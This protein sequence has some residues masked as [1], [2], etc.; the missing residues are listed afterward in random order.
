MK[1]GLVGSLL[2]GERNIRKIRLQPLCHQW[3][4][5]S[6][7]ERDKR[8]GACN[9]SQPSSVRERT[10]RHGAVTVEIV[11]AISFCVF[12]SSG[13]IFQSY[14]LQ[15]VAKRRKKNYTKVYLV[16]DNRSLCSFSS[17]HGPHTHTHHQC[18]SF[19]MPFCLFVCLFVFL[20]D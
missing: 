1:K 9:E 16:Q 15:Y 5:D 4:R 17:F 14:G 6:A 19:C 12:D 10:F 11:I 13:M 7:R 20:F 2:A 18:L 3:A 8:I